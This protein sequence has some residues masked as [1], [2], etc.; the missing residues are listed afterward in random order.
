M[1]LDAEGGIK[2]KRQ[3][4]VFG[5]V[6]KSCGHGL[7]SERCVVVNIL[8]TVGTENFYTPAPREALFKSSQSSPV[9]PPKIRSPNFLPSDDVLNPFRCFV[10]GSVVFFVSSSRFVSCLSIVQVLCNLAGVV[11][12]LLRLDVIC[13]PLEVSLSTKFTI[14]HFLMMCFNID[15][16][17]WRLVLELFLLDDVSHCKALLLRTF[18]GFDLRL[19]RLILDCVSIFSWSFRSISDCAPISMFVSMHSTSSLRKRGLTL[20]ICVGLMLRFV[21]TS[22]FFTV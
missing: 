8:S 2:A 18:L 10:K 7:W 12:E 16:P 21:T 13:V 6:L 19:V 17:S 4:F 9:V 11:L 20:V 1:C 22:E 3:P 14:L 15:L 5:V